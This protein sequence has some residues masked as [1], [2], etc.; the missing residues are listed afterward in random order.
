[1]R[2]L[3]LFHFP[4]FFVLNNANLCRFAL[5]VF[6]DVN[7]SGWKPATE[8]QDPIWMQVS[9]NF[10]ELR[11]FVYE[12]ESVQRYILYASRGSQLTE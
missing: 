4:A 5:E 9:V 6:P 10:S 12:V 1:M 8:A 7:A 3:A 11:L 2:Y